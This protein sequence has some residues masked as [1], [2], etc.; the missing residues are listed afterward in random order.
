MENSSGQKLCVWKPGDKKIREEKT[1]N[2]FENFEYIPKLLTFPKYNRKVHRIGEIVALT[3]NN[4]N[5][6]VT[7]KITGFTTRSISSPI[8]VSEKTDNTNTRSLF[9][10]IKYSHKDTATTHTNTHTQTEKIIK[11]KIYC[12]VHI[13]RIELNI[14][15]NFWFVVGRNLSPPTDY[16]CWHWSVVRIIY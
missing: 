1:R 9:V 4:L 11:K 5:I 15:V 14:Y 6:F 7:E 12:T 3:N 16:D 10:L 2:N 8:C 13:I